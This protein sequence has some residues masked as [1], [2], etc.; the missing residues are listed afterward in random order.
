MRDEAELAVVFVS[1]GPLVA[2]VARAK[3]EAEGLPVMLR[4]EAVG[5]AL[6]LTFDGLGRVEVCVRPEDA[7]AARAILEPAK[8]V[9]SEKPGEFEPPES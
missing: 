3:L 4:F 6:G 5:R 2:E 9:A 1:Q 8:D 7:A